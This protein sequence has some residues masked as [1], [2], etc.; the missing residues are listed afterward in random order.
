MRRAP[1]MIAATLLL[2][3]CQ[4]HE[5]EVGAVVATAATLQVIQLAQQQNP[6]HPGATGECCMVCGSC[7]FPC[8]D[9]CVPFGTVCTD[10]AGCACTVVPPRSNLDPVPDDARDLGCDARLYLPLP[11]AD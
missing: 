11:G 10:P 9:Y 5:P 7:E 2:A 1:T 8:G 3:A 6:D 4:G